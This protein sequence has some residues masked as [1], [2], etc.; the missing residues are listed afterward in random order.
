MEN[1]GKIDKVLAQGV[2]ADR[3]SGRKNICRPDIGQDFTAGR[4]EFA[5]VVDSASRLHIVVGKELIGGMNT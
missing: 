4:Y 3:L 1:V 5:A 2:L